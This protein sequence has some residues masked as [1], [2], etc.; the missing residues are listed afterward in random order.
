MPLALVPQA[1]T[2]KLI[3]PVNEISY[4]INSTFGDL[5]PLPFLPLAPINFNY[6]SFVISEIHL[7]TSFLQ[8]ADRIYTIVV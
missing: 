4:F 1:L 8:D 5:L 6:F 7:A 2:A 3:T